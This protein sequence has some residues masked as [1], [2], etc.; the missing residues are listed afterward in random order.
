MQPISFARG[1]CHWQNDSAF[2]SGLSHGVSSM[3]LTCP[4]CNSRIDR[5]G[6]D[7]AD[8]VLCPACKVAVHPTP[9]ATSL[10]TPPSAVAIG[11]TIGHYRVEEKIGGGG[12]GVVYKAHD[13]KLGRSV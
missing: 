13:T 1:A 9:D 2:T 3:Q 5:A 6:G 7:P 10:Y 11:H 12:M 4:E 8:S